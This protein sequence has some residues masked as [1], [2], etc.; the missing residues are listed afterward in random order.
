MTISAERD[1]DTRVDA[2]LVFY[3]CLPRVKLIEKA[4]VEV[5]T[6]TQIEF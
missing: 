5:K 6:K 1:L 2:E 4:D 3:K